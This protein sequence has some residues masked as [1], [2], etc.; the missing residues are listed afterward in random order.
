VA[1]IRKVSLIPLSIG[2][3]CKKNGRKDPYA[4]SNKEKDKNVK[5]NGNNITS[6][7]TRDQIYLEKQIEKNKMIGENITSR[8]T[9]NLFL[10]CFHL[11]L[12]HVQDII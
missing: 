1:E 10:S 4:A 9:R 12:V 6:Q 5:M 11:V 8:L 7:V 2:N 3:G